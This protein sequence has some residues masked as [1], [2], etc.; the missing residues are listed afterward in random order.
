MFSGIGGLELG[1]EAAGV[2]QVAW[3]CEIDP[4]ARAVLA[5]HWPRVPCF[6]DVRTMAPPPVDV[7]CAGFPCQ[8]LSV[9]GKGAG[10]A[11]E[12]SGLFWE[13]MRVV[14][15]VGPRF[16]VL[17][18]V[19]ALL[20]RGFGTILGALAARGFDAEWHVLAA[21]DVGAPHLR[22]RLFIIAWRPVA[23]AHG[24]RQPQ[25]QGGQRDGR[26]RPGNGRPVADTDR[27]DAVK[28]Q[29]IR[30]RGHAAVARRAGESLADPHRPGPSQREGEPRDH[31]EE[32]PAAVG[33]G[34]RAA[35]P[36]LG[37]DVDGLPRRLDVD[38]H[39]WPAGR[40]PDQHPNEPPRLVPPGTRGRAAR[41]RALGNAVVPQV[42][43]VI[44]RRLLE[45]ACS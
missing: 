22:R 10:L 18:N 9:A 38:G 44:G 37:G 7:I 2:G 21:A 23:D 15:L 35:K 13:V 24:L 43:E 27:D 33:G 8:D 5:R 29:R 12:R 6:P 1:L 17:E 34:R 3:Q 31:G 28:P 42:A 20:V 25:P 14:D 32:R 41:I 39:R 36:A 11:G 26:R 40:G 45:I 16:I 4:A 19:P 30:R